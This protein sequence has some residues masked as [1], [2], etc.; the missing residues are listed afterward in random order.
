MC[1]FLNSQIRR[2]LIGLSSKAE[3]APSA[4]LLAHAALLSSRKHTKRRA[5]LWYLSAANRLEKCGI[6]SKDTRSCT[7][8]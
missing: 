2:R 3:E 1:V 5:A 8:E 4:L 7:K 6:V